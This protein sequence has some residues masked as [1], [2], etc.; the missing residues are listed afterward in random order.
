MGT[1]RL[2]RR[3]LL[4]LGT[5]A[6]I[7]PVGHAETRDLVGLTVNQNPRPG[8]SIWPVTDLP[9]QT[10]GFELSELP[11]EEFRIVIPE[12]ISDD[13][14]PILPWEQPSP[15]WNIG[16]GTARCSIEIQDKIHMDAEVL[17]C[18]ERI[19]TRVAAT[20]LSQVTWKNVNAFTCFAFYAAPSF[21]DP[22]LT[23]TYFPVDGQW[24]SVSVLFAEHDPGSGPYTF[25]PVAG[26]PQ[27]ED[28]WLGRKISQHHPQIV[29]K[30][31]ACVVSKDG[32]WIAGMAT[33]TPAYAFHNRR[34]RC[35][36]ADP[37]LGTIPPD[38]TAEGVATVFIFRGTFTD[39][40]RQCNAEKPF[41]CESREVFRKSGG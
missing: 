32:R 41:P 39:F 2:T 4:K 24:K 3:K 8:V 1:R 29:S 19:V 21:D 13:T 28:L 11:G 35:I 23:R 37:L 27:L 15:K 31:C 9:H 10:I 36:H 6:L 5:S 17:F 26:G 7:F 20:N 18:K 30:G 40:T 16:R 25:F 33:R 38:T 12:L 34:E 14:E 22:E